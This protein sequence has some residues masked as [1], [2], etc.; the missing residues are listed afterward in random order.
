MAVKSLSI[1]S[2]MQGRRGLLSMT[3]GLVEGVFCYETAAFLNGMSQFG[4]DVL[5]MYCPAIT[6]PINAGTIVYYPTN[7]G[8]L[9]LD[10]CDVRAEGVYVTNPIRTIRELIAKGAYPEQVCE[11]LNWWNRKYGSLGGVIIDLEL[12]GLKDRLQPYFDAM[13]LYGYSYKLWEGD[14]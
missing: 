7:T 1:N 3:N 8:F 10:E 9:N 14:I 2:L 13:Q 12:N 4:D 5:Y 6:E 11:C